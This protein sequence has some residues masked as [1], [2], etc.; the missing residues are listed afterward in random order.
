MLTE[1]LQENLFKLV[2]SLESLNK[3]GY[4]DFLIK[5][6][7]MYN[8]YE[9]VI[10][11]EINTS[12]K[13]I[14]E[15]N[16]DI[17]R[18][19]ENIINRK[20]I[21]TS[22]FESN[23]DSYV[24]VNIAKINNKGFTLFPEDC[25]NLFNN[26]LKTRYNE[27]IADSIRLIKLKRLLEILDN[28]EEH[29]VKRR[30]EEI[31]SNEYLPLTMG[32]EPVKEQHNE[33]KE[34]N[35]YFILDPSTFYFLNEVAADSFF[36]GIWGGFAQIIQ[37]SQ[38]C[39]YQYDEIEEIEDIENIDV[40]DYDLESMNDGLFVIDHLFLISKIKV[41]IDARLYYEGQVFDERIYKMLDGNLI[42]KNLRGFHNGYYCPIGKSELLASLPYSIDI[43]ESIRKIIYYVETLPLSEQKESV[44]KHILKKFDE[45]G[46]LQHKEIW[47]FLNKEYFQELSEIE[48][49]IGDR[50]IENET[51]LK[52]IFEVVKP[53]DEIPSFID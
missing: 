25:P 7:H 46:Y 50:L 52:Q 4:F 18:I 1:K 17:V 24:T 42:N 9:Y 20:D 27:K 33:N 26:E 8:N 37:D 38:I 48:K 41:F 35:G 12:E 34:I 6:A 16:S 19:A 2:Y 40:F 43:I 10:V 11:A 45:K 51:I 47:E 22:E 32:D 53:S 23:Q 39:T 5:C 49:R 15:E 36:P 14:I 30:L 21:D 28:L 29:E 44:V 3:Q 31:Y 13:D